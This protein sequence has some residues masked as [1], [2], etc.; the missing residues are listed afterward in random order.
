MS[1][2]GERKTHVDGEQIAAY[3]D[4]KLTPAERSEIEVHLADCTACRTELLSVTRILQTRLFKRRLYT[5]GPIAAA[6]VLAGLLFFV[7]DGSRN[8]TV[9]GARRAADAGTEGIGQLEIVGPS[10]EIAVRRADLS[11]GWR[12]VGDAVLYRLAVLDAAGNE[13]WTGSTTDST[14]ALPAAV[15]LDSDVNYFWYVDALLPDGRSATTGM[16]QFRIAP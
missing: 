6:A 7:P 11:F 1:T 9:E 3:L 2:N 5:F 15:T 8:T 10:E 16:R 14:L 13:V 12:S 4:R